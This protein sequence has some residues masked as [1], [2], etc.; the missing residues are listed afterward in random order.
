MIDSFQIEK[1]LIFCGFLVMQNRLKDATKSVISELRAADI[2]N[3]MVTGDNMLTALSVARDSN[4][5]S[6]SDKVSSL[7]TL[8][9]YIALHL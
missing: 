3:V 4:I 8:K 6:A 2:R 9:Q 7:R 5:I 1:D